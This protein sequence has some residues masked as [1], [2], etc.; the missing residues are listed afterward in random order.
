MLVPLLLAAL[1]PAATAEVSP[2]RARPG[3][4]V[5]V[6]VAG[7]T[8]A[9]EGVLLGRPLRFFPAGE[10]RWRALAPLPTEAAP[11]PAA[12]SLA[13]GGAPVPVA[14][15]IEAAA[16]RSTRLSVAPRFL[17]PP[18]SAAARIAADAAALAEAYRQPFEPP[19]FGAAFARPRAAEVT[20][21]YGDQRVFNGTAASVHYGL[22]L[23]G[24]RGDPVLA[25]ADGVVVLARRCYH[26]GWTTVLWHGAGVYSS[27]LHQA[28]VEVGPGARVA[29]GQR[30][31]QVG[32]TGRS[33]GPHLHWGVK[34]DGLWVDP[35]SVL[36]LDLGDPPRPAAIP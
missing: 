32:S 26:S 14:L 15:E 19:L 30:I 29:R 11:G 25:A 27:Y 34:V 4:A 28:A 5:L 36:R 21:R 2:P 22:D 23:D 24:A 3:D 17:S 20:G 18:A 9:P 8:A 16:F 12:L 13:S 10:G 6:T 31:G 7:A 35:E 33:T 1:L